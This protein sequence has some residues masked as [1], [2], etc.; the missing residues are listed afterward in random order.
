MPSS[1]RCRVPH[2]PPGQRQRKSAQHGSQ[3]SPGQRVP[4]GPGVSVPDFYEGRPTFPRRRQEVCAGADRPAETFFLFHRARRIFFL[5]SL[6]RAPAAPRAVGRGEARERAQFSPQAET[7]LSGLCDD[8]GG[9]IC[10]A[11]ILAELFRKEDVDH[12]QTGRTGVRRAAPD[13]DHP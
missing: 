7:E 10:P 3:T 2:K 11:S 4:Q 13:Q 8:N 6:C 5:M 12:D 1:A 9:R